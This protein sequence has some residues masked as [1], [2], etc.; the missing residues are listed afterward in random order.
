M[1]QPPVIEKACA[2]LTSYSHAIEFGPSQAQALVE[3]VQKY[4]EIF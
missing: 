2:Y 4:F 3:G 1:Y